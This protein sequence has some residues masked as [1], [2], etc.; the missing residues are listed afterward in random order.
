MLSGAGSSVLL[1]LRQE[2]SQR[3]VREAVGARL[4]AAQLEGELIFTRMAAEGARRAELPARAL[5]EEG[6]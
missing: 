3:E 4:R 5:A 6:V 1:T 2:A